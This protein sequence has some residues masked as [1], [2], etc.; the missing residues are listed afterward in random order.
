MK[1]IPLLFLVCLLI[2][3][4]N[5]KQPHQIE[6]GAIVPLTGYSAANGV[7][8]YQGLELAISEI[9]QDGS[10]VYFNLDLEDC[11]SSPKEALMAYRKLKS[12]GIKYFIGF[13]GQFV[14]GFASETDN[15]DDILFTS[16]TPNTNILSLSNRSLRIF[17][18]TDMVTDI[19]R[20]F[21]IEKGYTRI[22]IIYAQNDAYAMYYESAMRKL[23]AAEKDVVFV[24]S[25]DPNCRDFK[26]IVNKLSQ[27]KV[28][29]IYSAGLGESSALL[30][31]QIF[32]NP[33]TSNIPIIGDMNFSTPENINIVGEIKSPLY[34][35]DSYMSETFVEKYK[36]KYQNSPNAYSVYG[37]VIPFLLKESLVEKGITSSADEVYEYILTNVFST[38]AGVISFDLQTREPVLNIVVNTLN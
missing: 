19:I 30:T 11:K 29:V 8:F 23:Q 20:D 24:E 21:I 27:Y 5:Q 4:C 28:D 12:N 6:I 3:G 15:T 2:S 18:N 33:L 16:A 13:G 36:T 25:Y 34:S 22:A 9:N 14:L 35:V 10:N 17:P 37:Y 7:L 26:D 31:K 32:N 38:A 1:R